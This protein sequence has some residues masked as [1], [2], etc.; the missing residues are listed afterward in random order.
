MDHVDPIERAFQLARDGQHQSVEGIR[1]TL[2][3]EGRN[4]DVIT[5]P[6][7]VRQLRTIIRNTSAAG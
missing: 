6:T 5:G 7:L 2:R 1:K 3:D 4:S